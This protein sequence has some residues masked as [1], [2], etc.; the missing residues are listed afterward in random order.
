MSKNWSLWRIEEPTDPLYSVGGNGLIRIFR[1]RMEYEADKF[2]RIE[3]S[4]RVAGS[5]NSIA[6][7]TL[8]VER[9]NAGKEDP[10]E[11]SFWKMMFDENSGA[12]GRQVPFSPSEPLS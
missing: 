5:V 10:P 6:A 7:L 4:F 11:T 9:I 12:Y 3:E 2:Y 1:F 8:M